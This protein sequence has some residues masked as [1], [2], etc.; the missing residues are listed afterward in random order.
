MQHFFVKII[1][2]IEMNKTGKVG[3]QSKQWIS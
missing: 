3:F 1:K 2:I